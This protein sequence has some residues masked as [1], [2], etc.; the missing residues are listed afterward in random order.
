[1]KKIIAVILCLAFLTGLAIIPVSA[2]DP[3]TINVPKAQTS[4]VLD[5]KID[6]D[7]WAGAYMHDLRPGS[8]I[9]LWD[10][11][12]SGLGTY[13]GS[14]FWY[15]WNE[16]GLYAAADVKMDMSIFETPERGD[17]NYVAGSVQFCIWD[18]D[19]GGMHLWLTCHIEA[20]DGK[21]VITNANVGMED[22][23]GITMAAVKKSDGYTAEV[24]ISSAALAEYGINAVSGGKLMMLTD[25][26]YWD[27]DADTV[28]CACDSPNWAALHTYV[29]TDTAA[30]K[31]PQAE[32]APEPEVVAAPE[33][34]APAPA[35]EVDVDDTPAPAAPAAPRV[36]DEGFIGV[37][38][39]AVLASGT[40][41]VLRKKIL[42]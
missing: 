35:V 30:G 38:L 13:N 29:L 22:A 34:A 40:F 25:T 20:A 32:A 7:E 4:P 18:G 10:A 26:I 37:I 21:P 2:F 19:G 5:G 41:A 15:M 28:E 3:I 8:G 23:P 24:L 31:A 36:G 39:I 12:G 6:A 17:A 42:I 1:M 14:V 16:D 9:E 33:E 11:Y 27:T